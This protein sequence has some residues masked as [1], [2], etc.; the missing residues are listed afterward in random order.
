[1]DL[2]HHRRFACM[3]LAAGL[4]LAQ[5]ELRADVSRTTSPELS[6]C[7][8]AQ[9][10]QSTSEPAIAALARS[11]AVPLKKAKARKVIVLNF[12]GSGGKPHPVGKWLADQLSA[13]IRI[14]YPKINTIDRSKLISD[15]DISVDPFD[16]NAISQMERS[17]ARSVGADVAIVG[18]FA[19][20]SNQI[21]V[22]LRVFR[23]DDPNWGFEPKTGLVP[24]SKEIAALTSE[25]IPALALEDGY[26]R[27]GQ[28]GIGMPICVHCP[29][30][31]HADRAGVVILKVVV[32]TDGLP[33]RI[34][35]WQSPDPDL[36][37]IAIRTVQAWRFKPALR[38]DGN[39]VAVIIPIQI[40]F[41]R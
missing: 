23:V 33:D 19:A 11:L 9:G 4:C 21:A 22:T 16:S 30:P 13:A 6:T 26:P 36:S 35:V 24:L 14:E 10:S 20:V 2:A 15:G 12:L 3:T 31:Q 37:A 38:G 40:T 32:T 27:G 28:S 39:P 17:R 1:M 29:P 5:A 8:D 34:K 7:D 18:D 25:A 41:I